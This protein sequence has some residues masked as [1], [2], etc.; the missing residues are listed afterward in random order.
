MANRQNADMAV[1][2]KLLRPALVV[3][4]NTLVERSTFLSRLLIGLAD[5]SIAT[6]LICPRGYDV[7][8][9][10]PP[11]ISVLTYPLMDLPLVEY[12][13]V[14]WL[15]AQVAKFKPTVLHSL[16]ESEAVLT[17]R[18]ARR[19]DLPYVQTVHSLVGRFER[20]RVCPQHCAAISAP[21]ES[22]CTRLSE[23]HP[24]LAD[25]IRQIHIGTFIEED[26][27]CFSDSSRLTSIVL[28]QPLRRAS[29]FEPFFR[30]VKALL[31]EGR[32]FLVVIMGSGP[33]EHRL[34]RLL[35]KL[36]LSQAVTIVPILD[37]WRSVLAAGD[38]FVQPQPAKAFSTFLLEAMGL[39]TAVAACLGGVDDLLVP[40]RTA[41]IFDPNDEQSIRQTLTRLLDEPD[42]ARRLARMAQDHVRA[43]YSVSQMI[44]ATIEMYAQAQQYRD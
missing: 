21:A 17:C 18:L 9:I 31:A 28:A 44:A 40:D 19:L 32:E 27:I 14:G 25:R 22:I 36:E 43:D 26:T 13:G 10:V 30:A 5:E 16:C 34:R 1:I 24:R 3:S 39:G 41:V 12:F 38:I 2:R 35:E 20:I 8:S 37:P 6:T 42:F 29:D 11:P 23:T 33:A 15:A 7:E 4:R